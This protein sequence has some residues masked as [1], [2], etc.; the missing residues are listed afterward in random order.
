MGVA[1]LT[2]LSREEFQ[3]IVQRVVSELQRKY[4]GRLLYV[5]AYGSLA[6]G[7]ETPLSDVD[8][9]A[10]V[11]EGEAEERGWLY[12][13]TP[14][15]VRV[16]PLRQVR[17][18]IL[19]VDG[20]WPHVA[21]AFLSHKVYLDQGG[22]AQQLR[23]WHVEALEN[24]KMETHAG[25]YEY[26]GKMQRGWE[27]RNPEV[28]RRAAWE[29]FFM[30]CM[31]LALLN[32]RFYIDHMRMTEE[33]EDFELLPEGFLEHAKKLFHP[34][35]EQVYLAAKDLFEIHLRLAREHG[36]E[37]ESLSHVEEIRID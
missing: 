17:E 15:D 23:R 13:T 33:I 21:G 14:I 1:M 3:S 22:V 26:M 24:V 18:R 19:Q 2:P 16:L 35:L 34:D 8:L 28:V 29:L 4:G 5:G 20:F 32:K 9:L 27:E 25:F 11:D 10:I 6:R 31:D 7:A 12:G 36:Y 37:M 30:S